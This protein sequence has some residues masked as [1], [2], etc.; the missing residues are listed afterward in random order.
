ML[1]F[2]AWWVVDFAHKL[3]AGTVFLLSYAGLFCQRAILLEGLT[4]T[5]SGSDPQIRPEITSN[6]DLSVAFVKMLRKP[7][8][9]LRSALKGYKAEAVVLVRY[10]FDLTLLTSSIT[11]S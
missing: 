2:G 5:Q 11:S 3:P 10:V 6:T 4:S 1:F 9:D 7:R 8:N